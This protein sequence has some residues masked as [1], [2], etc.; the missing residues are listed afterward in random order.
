MTTPRGRSVPIAA[1]PRYMHD[2]GCIGAACEE[3]CCHGWQVTVDKPTYQRCRDVAAPDIGPRLRENLVR[4]PAREHGTHHATIRLAPD[5]ACPFLNAERLC[6]VHRTL[7]PDF[8]SRTCREYPRHYVRRDGGLSLWATLSCPEAARRA[9]LDPDSMVVSEHALPFPY[10]TLVP[11][12]LTTAAS[13]DPDAPPERVLATIAYHT[14]CWLVSSARCAT[15]GTI[16][17]GMMVR[18][19]GAESTLEGMLGVLRR[20]QDPGAVGELHDAID[21]IEPH[22]DVQWLLLSDITGAYLR[23]SGGRASFRET[24]AEGLRALDDGRADRD[25]AAARLKEARERWFDPFD[26]AHPHLLRN[27]VLND[28]GR[29][30]FPLGRGQS[31]EAAFLD[32]AVRVALVRLYLVGL[33]A[34]RQAAFGEDA[35]VEVVYRFVR[36]VE[37]NAG[38]MRWVTG[39]LAEEGYAGLGTA[40][41]LLR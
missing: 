25:A 35:Y 13:T 28:F 30:A 40:A 4:R 10:A 32:A 8:L 19:L 12:G 17:V 38:F 6:D 23:R 21:R 9:L 36:N 14:A 1:S 29:T 3:N 20:Y 27:Y 5:G 41:I 37:H 33:A 7:G 15:D 2:F 31:M 39:R 24:V 22:P 34:S 26:R 11:P 18:A 16:A